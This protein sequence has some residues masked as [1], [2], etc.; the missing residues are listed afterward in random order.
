MLLQTRKHAI[1]RNAKRHVYTYVLVCLCGSFHS[2]AI[3]A[4]VEKF[5][6]YQAFY[7]MLSLSYLLSVRL[8]LRLTFVRSVKGV[9]GS[10][11][12]KRIFMNIT[13]IGS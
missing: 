4:R 8:Y 6:P 13:P 5:D 10:Q 12:I 7:R 9:V 3:E 2:M 1:W 11:R